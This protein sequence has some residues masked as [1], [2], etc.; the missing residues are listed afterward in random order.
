[1]ALLL[2]PTDS[3]DMLFFGLLTAFA[4]SVVSILVAVLVPTKARAMLF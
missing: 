2:V 1:M 3:S 4:V